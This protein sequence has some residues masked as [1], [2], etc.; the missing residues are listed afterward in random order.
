LQGDAASTIA[1]NRIFQFQG[2]TGTFLSVSGNYDTANASVTGNTI[3]GN[4]TGVGIDYQLGTAAGLAVASTGNL[5]TGVTTQ[6]RV[7]TGVTVSAGV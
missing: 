2:G 1:N 6:R 3:R 4:G 7:G 5:V